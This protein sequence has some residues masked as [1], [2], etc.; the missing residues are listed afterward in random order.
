MKEKSE[1][2]GEYQEIRAPISGYYV[3]NESITMG[4]MVPALQPLA[5]ITPANIP[6]EVEGYVL[7]RDI[8][9]FDTD[10]PIKLK[11]DAYPSGDYG[12]VGGWVSYISPVPFVHEKMGSVYL[13]RA[14]LENANNSIILT[15]GLTGT[16]EIDID[17]R[18]VLSYLIEPI[19]KGLDSSFKEK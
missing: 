12:S 5:T 8:A 11:L 4:L 15:P 18:T 7:N 2:Y 16:M 14:R 10:T 17:K 19:T 1:V 3:G 9:S 13:V 6:V